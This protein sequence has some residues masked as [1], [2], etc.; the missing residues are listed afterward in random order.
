MKGALNMINGTN[1]NNVDYAN[2]DE[3]DF[4][5]PFNTDDSFE[6]TNGDFSG[7]DTSDVNTSE[8]LTR[9]EWKQLLTKV[10]T[11]HPQNEKE[12]LNIIRD[13]MGADLHHDQT[14]ESDDISQ[15]SD[16][17][18]DDPLNYLNG[19]NNTD[20]NSDTNNSDGATKVDSDGTRHFIATKDNTDFDLIA[21]GKK[22][23]NI[24]DTAGNVSLTPSSPDDTVQ[25]S[26]E[27]KYNVF[28]FS[29]GDVYKVDKRA[30]VYVASD[31]VSGDVDGN[32]KISY[33]VSKQQALISSSKITDIANI[34]GSSISQIGFTTYSL[35]DDNNLQ[36]NPNGKYSVGYKDGDDIN[37]F[38]NLTHFIGQ[39]AI[40]EANG[41]SGVKIAT[42]EA[43]SVK[44][45]L[46]KIQNAINEK[47]PETQTSLWSSISDDIKRWSSDDGSSGGIGNDKAQLL[48]NVLYGELG[49]EKF[50]WALQNG[51]LPSSFVSAVNS[52]LTAVAAEN[53]DRKE[54]DWYQTGGPG[55]THQ[56]SAD[57]LD[58]YSN[59]GSSSVE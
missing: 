2:N 29:S 41:S 1:K 52:S 32:G 10:K 18:G 43:N 3:L 17:L 40:D 8:N 5:D 22:S 24:I 51:V 11:E 47:N 45:E 34:I 4:Q 30:T 46:A 6:N 36:V 9:N 25:V 12:L 58:K 15:L 28:T 44:E 57:F 50:K 49:E 54:I 23:K 38:R 56:S 42:D 53:T 16:A 33:G 48:F 59:T 31:S 26:Q 27:G 35:V 13:A 39:Q 14:R 55:W 19:Q 20:N 7:T 21:S 37:N